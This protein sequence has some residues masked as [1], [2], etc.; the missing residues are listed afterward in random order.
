LISS[1]DA[2]IQMFMNLD[3]DLCDPFQQTQGITTP[4]P[5]LKIQ[6]SSPS[7]ITMGGGGVDSCTVA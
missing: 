7:T 1:N 2:K 4:D 6:N 3:V 5:L